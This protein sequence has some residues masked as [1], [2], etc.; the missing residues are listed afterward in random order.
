MLDRSNDVKLECNTECIYINDSY[1]C[2]QPMG[3]TGAHP[4]D[5]YYATRQYHEPN[6]VV[7]KITLLK[8]D[9]KLFELLQDSLD[10]W[11]TNDKIVIKYNKPH[12]YKKFISVK[13]EYKERYDELIMKN[14]LLTRAGLNWLA[15]KR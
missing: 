1:I 3:G 4:P 5:P 7:L 8:D 15:A 6:A 13:E 9:I 2:R 10:N 11:Y 12:P 14:K